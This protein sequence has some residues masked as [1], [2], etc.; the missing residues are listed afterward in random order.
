MLLAGPDHERRISL[1]SLIRARS[2]GTDEIRQVLKTDVSHLRR[3]S[4]AL[5][6][7]RP[8]L[9]PEEVYWRC[10][11]P[12]ACCNPLRRVRPRLNV[13]LGG[14]TSEADV[15]ALLERM[16]SSRRG[17]LPRLRR[18]GTWTAPAR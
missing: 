11:S 1:Q 15:V 3:F 6:R 5:L 16:L 10:T 12:W 18:S 14:Q 9:S 4:D 8:E 13:L 2:E 7:A 17:R